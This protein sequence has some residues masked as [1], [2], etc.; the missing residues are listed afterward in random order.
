MFFSLLGDKV[1]E[2]MVSDSEIIDGKSWFFNRNII[3]YCLVFTIILR[4][5]FLA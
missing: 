2:S 3:R 1:T 5:S 4:Y